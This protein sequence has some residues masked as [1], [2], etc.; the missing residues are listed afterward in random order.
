MADET[1][2][3]CPKPGAYHGIPD[4]DYHGREIC[5]A[6]SISASGLK[7]IE[8]K[9]P[10][11]YWVQSP[12]NPDRRPQPSTSHFAIGH[13]IHDVLLYGGMVPGE[14]HIVPDGFVRA[15]STKWADEI[16]A[17]DEAV[18]GGKHVLQRHEFEMVRA[19]AEACDSHELAGALLQ[20]GEPEVTLVAEDP[21]TGRP[22]RARPDILPATMEIIPDVKTAVSGHPDEFE[23]AASRY[24]Y[25]QS[26]ALYLD[27]L[28]ALYGEAQRKFVLIVIEKG[29]PQEKHYPG[30]PYPVTIYHLDDGNI[31]Y[32]RML[33]RRALDRFDQCLKTGTWPAYS[34][35]D[36]PILPLVLAPWERRRIDRMIDAGELSYEL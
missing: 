1:A 16:E 26:A 12:L 22:V 13:L 19:M 35:P 8:A 30:R 3:L 11:H 4:D 6:P 9:S 21:K 28:E 27:I 31:H 33:N 20:S 7:L 2:P 23:S 25:F 34:S 32:G 36:K 29:S 17:Y 24:G 14:Y 18:K 5:W 10:F 15:H